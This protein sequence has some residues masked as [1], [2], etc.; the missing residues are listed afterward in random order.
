M[1]NGDTTAAAQGPGAATDPVGASL[2]GTTFAQ[3]AFGTLGVLLMAGEYSTGMIRSS[4]AAVPKRLPVLWAKIAV[5]SAVTFVLALAAAALAFTGGQALIGDG[6]ASWGDPGVARAVIGTAVVITGSGILGIGLGALLRS[7]PSAITTLFGVMFL[8]SGVA[9]LLLPDS[10]SDAVQY[11]PSNASG[12]FTAVTQATGALS[13]WA[14]LAV[15]G[16]Y[17]AAVTGAAALRLKRSDV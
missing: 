14:G 16:A 12:A 10:W 4:I 8:L 6:G 5:F 2:A 13:P 11:L 3:L 15:F 7:T 17:V 9:G 1:F